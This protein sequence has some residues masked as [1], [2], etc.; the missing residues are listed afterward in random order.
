MYDDFGNAGMAIADPGRIYGSVGLNICA[1]TSE[2]IALSIIAGLTTA[3]LLNQNLQRS[4][5]VVCDQPF[6]SNGLLSDF[7]E[8]KEQTGKGIVAASYQNTIGPPV[9]LSGYYFDEILQLQ[10]DEGE[11]KLIIKYAA[12]AAVVPFAEGAIDIG[13]PEDYKKLKN[14]YR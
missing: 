1:E 4:L 11:K 10:G 2:E 14:A 8:I 13:T 5:F 12:D 6:L 7:L 3:L 9:F